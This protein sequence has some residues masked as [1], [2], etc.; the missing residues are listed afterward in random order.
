MP[1]SWTEQARELADA[2]ERA[3]AA[4]DAVAM[5]ALLNGAAQCNMI[6]RLKAEA[7]G[8]LAAMERFEKARADLAGLLES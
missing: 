7:D 8:H 3:R 2:A 5:A 4:G 1:T 6:A